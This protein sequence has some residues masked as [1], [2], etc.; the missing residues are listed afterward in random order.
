MGLL[1]VSMDNNWEGIGDREQGKVR[2]KEG[3]LVNQYLSTTYHFY[4]LISVS[5]KVLV[6]RR[7][8]ISDDRYIRKADISAFFL[9]SDFAD[10]RYQISAEAGISDIG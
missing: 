1:T 9:I 5:L 7:D 3:L 4:M 10:I 2:N 6:K 8:G